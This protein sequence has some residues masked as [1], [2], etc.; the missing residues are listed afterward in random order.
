MTRLIKQTISMVATVAL[1][2]EVQ[3]VRKNTLVSSLMIEGSTN[4]LVPG[5]HIHVEE[6]DLD[7]LLDVTAPSISGGGVGIEYIRLAGDI[8]ES[9]GKNC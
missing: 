9:E 3:L 1:A 8:R 5:E 2:R 6:Y 7:L 4:T